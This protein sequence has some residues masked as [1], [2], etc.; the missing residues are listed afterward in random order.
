MSEPGDDENDHPVPDDE[1]YLLINDVLRE[2]AEAVVVLLA[3]GRTHVRNGTT[4][5][6]G[7]DLTEGV[8]VHLL[9]T[10]EIKC[11]L[12]QIKYY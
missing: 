9:F 6:G 2:D 8:D 3:A 10:S 5:L 4:H 7:E 12:I 1:V 11:F